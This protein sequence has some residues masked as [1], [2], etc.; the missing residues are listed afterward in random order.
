M[1]AHL[2]DKGEQTV[3]AILL[4]LDKKYTKSIFKQY[5]LVINEIDNY[6]NESHKHYDKMME[7]IRKIVLVLSI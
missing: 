4:H 6:M 7:E 5:N 1:I 2:N 3:V